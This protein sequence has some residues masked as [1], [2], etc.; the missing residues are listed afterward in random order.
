MIRRDIYSTLAQALDETPAVCPLG[1]RPPSRIVRRTESRQEM[2]DIA[3][4]GINRTAK[5]R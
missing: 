3:L 5:L 1:Q 4:M 2:R